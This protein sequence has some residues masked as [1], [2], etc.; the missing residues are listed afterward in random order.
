VV[1]SGRNEADTCRDYV[2]P[3]LESSGW[4]RERLAEQYR[5]APGY[6]ITDGRVVFQGRRPTRADQVRADYVLELASGFPVAVVEAKREYAQPGDGL[7]QAKEYANLLDLPVAL[8]TNGHGIVEFDFHSGLERSLDVFPRPDEL[9]ERYRAWKGLADE[10]VAEV[11]REPFN[12]VLRNVDGSVKEP[13]YYQRVVDEPEVREPEPAGGEDENDA[14]EAVV[15]PHARKLYVDDAEVYLTADAVYLTDP[16]PDR[17][18]LVEYRDYAA[19]VVRRLFP[20]PAGLRRR[21]REAPSRAEV[22]DEL[23]RRGVDL[24]ELSERA[25]LPDADAFD[26]LVHVAWNEPVLTRDERARRVR[27]DHGEFFRGFQPEA[28]E[29]LDLLLERYAEHGVDDLADLRALELEPVN[30]L[31]TVVEIARRFGTS[32]RLRRAVSE[33]QRMLYAA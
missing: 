20:T 17:L 19:Q 15:P 18:R 12:R 5:I 24:D 33:L 30:E 23:R 14:T 26:V 22:A 21:W 16:E 29:V 6:R 8:A 2:L 9:W 25:N 11:L 10:E 28:R 1:R 4:R 3:A 7:Q 27:R 13:R 32:D 31:G